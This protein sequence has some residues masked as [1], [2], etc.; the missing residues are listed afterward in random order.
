M[1]SVRCA[2]VRLVGISDPGSNLRGKVV[3]TKVDWGQHGQ[4]RGSRGGHVGE[5]ERRRR[6]EWRRGNLEGFFV[7]K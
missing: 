1:G 6:T 7:G 5:P 4:R 3:V 2:V